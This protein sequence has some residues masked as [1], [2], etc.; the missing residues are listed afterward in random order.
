VVI[1]CRARR[2]PGNSRMCQVHEN[3]LIAL[4]AR[5]V[6]EIRAERE[7]ERLA[8]LAHEAH[9]QQQHLKVGGTCDD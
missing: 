8:L 3:E 7:L 1:G 5:R 2:V 9:E 4:I 6:Q